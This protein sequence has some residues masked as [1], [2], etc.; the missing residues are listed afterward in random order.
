[1]MFMDYFGFLNW[2]FFKKGNKSSKIWARCR[3]PTLWRRD[4]CNGEG[5]RRGVA[6]RRKCPASGSPWRSTAMLWRS[7]CSQHEKCHVLFC[8]A[9]PLFQGL[10]C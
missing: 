5:P 2:F 3:G 4:P 6:E 7:Y 10:V 9:I 8:S 1:M